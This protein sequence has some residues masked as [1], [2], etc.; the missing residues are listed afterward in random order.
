MK[1]DYI[2]QEQYDKWMDL[3]SKDPQIPSDFKQHPVAREVCIAGHFLK[4]EL[5][6]LN[7]PNDL[8]LRIFY[9]FGQLSHEAD[10]WDMAQLIIKE[11]KDGTL[12]FE[13]DELDDIVRQEDKFAIN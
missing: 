13:N 9:T 11:Y 6:A 2:S 4:Q 12:V 7:C 8:Q 10:P 1:P 5:D 3:V